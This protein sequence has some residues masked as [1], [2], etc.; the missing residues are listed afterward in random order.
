MFLIIYLICKQ[1]Q[2]QILLYS[3]NQI[4]DFYGYYH[5]NQNH[6]P[7]NNYTQQYLHN[8]LQI[9]SLL[10]TFLHNFFTCSLIVGSLYLKMDSTTGV[11]NFAELPI[12]IKMRRYPS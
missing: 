7:L 3:L 11:H 9:L 8:S 5:K 10:H 12:V 1:F 2:Y 4:Q 6:L